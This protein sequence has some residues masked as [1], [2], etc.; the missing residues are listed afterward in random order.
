MLILADKPTWFTSF[1]V[2]KKIKRLYPKTKVWHSG[3]LDPMATGLL[4]IWVW[5]DTKK[6]WEILLMD[7]EYLATID[8][9]K[10]SDTWDMDYWEVFEQLEVNSLPQ[11]S[12]E[13]LEK[14]LSWL[15][16]SC[17]L[18]LPDFS[19]KKI[20]WKKMYELAR[21]W[22]VLNR[23]K[24]MSIFKYE[25]INY[26]F[27]LLE[28]KITVWSGTYI[29]SIAYWLWEQFWLWGILTSLRRTRIWEFIL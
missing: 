18:P 24:V 26:S 5:P 22:Q 25:I 27:P 7:K 12:I 20:Q 4:V 8:F 1:D 6:L 19:A 10:K 9:S 2:V 13:D 11:P 21:E 14:K 17:E 29:R 3:T 16:P 28:V 15:I 23:T